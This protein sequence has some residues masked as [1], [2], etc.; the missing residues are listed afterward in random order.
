MPNLTLLL[1]LWLQQTKASICH[2][3]EWLQP[4][5][6]CFHLSLK[7]H[8]LVLLLFLPHLMEAITK[9]EQFNLTAWG[10]ATN[11]A[12]FSHHVATRIEIFHLI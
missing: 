11:I 8:N 9:R 7:L 2:L 12:M 3:I 4:K 1:S 6:K 5:L 10:A